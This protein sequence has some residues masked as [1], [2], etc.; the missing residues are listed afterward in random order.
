MPRPTPRPL[1]RALTL[2]GEARATPVY[3]EPDRLRVELEDPAFDPIR[4]RPEFQARVQDLSFPTDPFGPPEPA[5]A[6]D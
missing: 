1:D 6:P 2:I 5:K 4:P 3:R